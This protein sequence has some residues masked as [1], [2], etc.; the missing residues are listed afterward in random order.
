[1]SDHSE[2]W[3]WDLHA[4]KAVPAADRG[5]GDHMLGPYSSKFEAE[6]WQARVHERNE[7]WSEADEEWDEAGEG[8]KPDVSTE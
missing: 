7:E 4:N 3:Y 2:K 6:N 1:M 8:E 5:P